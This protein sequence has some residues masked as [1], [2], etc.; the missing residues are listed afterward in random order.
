MP[1]LAP[2]IIATLPV[3]FPAIIVGLLVCKKML[4]N[5]Q[6]LHPCQMTFIVEHITY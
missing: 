2:V 6:S 1:A 4:C 3:N 5:I